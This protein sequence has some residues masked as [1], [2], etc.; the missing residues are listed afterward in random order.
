[1]SSS[2]KQ[3]WKYEKTDTTGT[4]SSSTTSQPETE[5]LRQY[6]RSFSFHTLQSGYNQTQLQQQRHAPT[7]QQPQQHTQQAFPHSDF[8][9][10]SQSQAQQGMLN[11]ISFNVDATKR[12]RG[13][14]HTNPFSG[15]SLTSTQIQESLHGPKSATT[16]STTHNT[17]I[18]GNSSN[19][20]IQRP[21]NITNMMWTEIDQYNVSRGNDTAVQSQQQEQQQQSK[22]KMDLRFLLN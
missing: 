1:M 14:R 16:T 22:S 11:H 15:Q 6:Q 8:S 10:G 13:R 3:Q 7:I 12:K 4:A 9:I 20:E 17:V 18:T 5:Q 2:H 19:A 21:T